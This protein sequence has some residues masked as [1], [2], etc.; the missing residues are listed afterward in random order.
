MQLLVER[1]SETSYTTMVAI[2]IGALSFLVF[3]LGLIQG[4]SLEKFILAVLGPL[5]PAFLWGIREYREQREAADGAD[6][7]KEYVEKLWSNALKGNL[8]PIQV[9]SESRDLQNAIYDHRRS[10]PVIFDWIYHRL[11]TAQ[12]EQMN[13]AAET[14]VAEA[15]K[16]PKV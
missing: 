3:V 1:D 10:S 8:A 11:R 6:R 4:I 15:L 13:K 12:E 16:M 2:T 14:L 5:M 9:E 7:L